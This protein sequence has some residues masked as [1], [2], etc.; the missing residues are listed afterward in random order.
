MDDD[1]GWILTLKLHVMTDHYG[2]T[3][4]MGRPSLLKLE[5]GIALSC[6]KAAFES[7][8]NGEVNLNVTPIL[9]KALLMLTRYQSLPGHALKALELP[10]ITDSIDLD[11]SVSLSPEK[12]NGKLSSRSH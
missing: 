6:L 11:N 9:F 1:K 8:R 2:S 12:E 3:G 4:H 7:K 5:F 10:K